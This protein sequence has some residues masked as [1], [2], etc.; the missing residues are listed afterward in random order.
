MFIVSQRV[1]CV[2]V[3]LNF[4]LISFSP[5]KLFH[6][7]HH[8]RY[9]WIVLQKHFQTVPIWRDASPN[10]LTSLLIWSI[11][12]SFPRCIGFR[13]PR[14]MPLIYNFPVVRIILILHSYLSYTDHKFSVVS[15]F[16]NVN[17]YDGPVST[18]FVRNRLLK[19]HRGCF[20]FYIVGNLLLILLNRPK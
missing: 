10:S 11:H 1:I 18:P 5:A 12:R 20:L 2:F 3:L 6:H 8:L 19:F 7:Y 16:Q 13:Q 14:K 9:C 17:G 15:V 4:L